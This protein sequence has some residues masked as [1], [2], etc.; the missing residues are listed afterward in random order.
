MLAGP[1]YK[2]YSLNFFC[3]GGAIE[4]GETDDIV[5]LSDPNEEEKHGAVY[6]SAPGD[7]NSAF[8]IRLVTDAK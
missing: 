4:I 1:H 8:S 6:I 7:R 5:R 3:G 2:P